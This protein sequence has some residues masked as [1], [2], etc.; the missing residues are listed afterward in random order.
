[1]VNNSDI[2]KVI[3]SLKKNQSRD[4][5]GMINELFLPGVMGEDMKAAVLSLMNGVKVT[6]YFPPFTQLADI[7]TIF[8]NK[9]SRLEMSSDRG[10]FFS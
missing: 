6:G 5:A 4:P 7:C 10:C 3:K 1:M 9:A 2:D 8:K